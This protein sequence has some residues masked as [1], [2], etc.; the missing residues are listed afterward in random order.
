MASTYGRT[1]TPELLGDEDR[2]HGSLALKL[3]GN[4][5]AWIK[6]RVET[7][8]F[9]SDT[10]VVRHVSVDFRLRSWLPDAILTWGEDER[11]HYMP[12]ALLE[13]APLAAFDLRDE[14]GRA[15]SLLT[16]QKNAAIAAAMLSALAQTTVWTSL[17]MS[18]CWNE[19]GEAG[20]VPRDPRQI[21]VPR[22]LEDDL[23]R[24]TYLPY[25]S[26]DD[27]HGA[28][29]VLKSFP[30]PRPHTARPLDE[31]EWETSD[32][33]ATFT[34]N[35]TEEEWRW[36]LIRDPRMRQLLRDMAHL[37]M[38]SVPIKD[39]P[40]RRRL[41]KFCYQEHRLEP[42]FTLSRKVRESLGARRLGR[43]LGRLQDWLEALPRDTSPTEWIPR[44]REHALPR[45]VS[46]MTK[47]R[48][49]LGWAGH[50]VE[51]EAPAVGEGG[52][53]HL[54]L[55]A[56]EGTQIR[57]ATLAAVSGDEVLDDH[58]LR[59]ARGLTRAHLFV[60]DIQPGS[61]GVAQVV[62][63]PRTTT[64]VRSIAIL[65]TLSVALLIVTRWKLDVLI[66]RKRGTAGTI[67]PI[68]LLFPGLASGVAS[69]STEHP[70]TNSMLF[71]M[72][73]MAVA[74]AGPPLVAAALLAVA[75]RSPHINLACTVLLI[76]ALFGWVALIVSW[77]LASRRR[78]DG[79]A[80]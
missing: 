77:R 9:V 54:E 75:R 47:F 68:L 43:S 60:G 16:R 61:R 39:E 22:T 69:R 59:G 19:R 57:R 31:W 52:S 18:P 2:H 40:R 15:L 21:I 55:E 46:V 45:D 37:W 36:L 63:K 70:M 13:K 33:G 25:E 10:I 3:V 73:M 66:D 12:L 26:Q 41:I 64:I 51:F 17:S 5:D 74:T 58:R 76:V 24:I 11:F 4:W 72:R 78:P 71:G 1:I 49:A 14:S 34:S 27:Q 35:A 8:E 67:F 32:G 38:V 65:S 20:R 56:P 48:Q 80:P 50:V 23:F 44:G 7:I 30:G 53:Y 28:G 62:L 6:R 79:S 29:D 42:Q